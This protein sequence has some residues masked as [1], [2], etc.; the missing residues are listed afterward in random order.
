MNLGDEIASIADADY[1]HYD[2]MD[3]QFVPNLS[4]GPDILAAATRASE[5]PFDVHLMTSFSACAST[6]ATSP[7]EATT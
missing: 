5:L 3:G 1:V 6:P 7:T 2:V 4:Y